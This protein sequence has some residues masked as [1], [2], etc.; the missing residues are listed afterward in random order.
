[1]CGHS[2]SEDT[3]ALVKPWMAEQAPGPSERH[4]SVTQITLHSTS[5]CFTAQFLSAEPSC[6]L[7][8][9]LHLQ[10]LGHRGLPLH[11]DLALPQDPARSRNGSTGEPQLL[12]PAPPQQPQ[13]QKSSGHF[14]MEQHLGDAAGCGFPVWVWAH[15][16]GNA[17][18]NQPL[19]SLPSTTH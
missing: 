2:P 16:A 8:C 15:S 6:E 10:A 4:C 13:S 12:P 5:E 11:A 14:S 9:R 19:A 17:R 3:Q 1:M 7:C 18:W